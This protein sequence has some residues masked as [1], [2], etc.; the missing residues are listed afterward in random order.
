[1]TEQEQKV[2][3]FPWRCPE[4]GKKEVYPSTS[5]YETEAK[6]DGRLYALVIDKLD[7]PT[8]RSCGEQVF[9]NDI[10]E[11]I[12]RALRAKLKLLSPEEIRYKVSELGLSQKEIARCLGVAEASFS[13]WVTGTVIQSRAMDKLLRLYFGSSEARRLL[14]EKEQSCIPDMSQ[15]EHVLDR[16]R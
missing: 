9:S 16:Y 12:S 4:C 14:S 3:A 11:E 2:R 1:M 8:C 5:S 6:H 7:I 13:R 15:P 10:D